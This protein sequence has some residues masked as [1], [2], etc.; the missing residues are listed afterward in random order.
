MESL[1]EECKNEQSL[2]NQTGRTWNTLREQLSELAL[3]HHIINE[4]SL[5]NG[6][7]LFG[8]EV[9]AVEAD[10]VVFQ[11]SGSSGMT[12]VLVPLVQIV[13]L[14]TDQYPIAPR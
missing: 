5:I 3:Q 10:Y 8:V 11:E 9:E 2:L 4:V 1:F 7:S 13:Y 6:Q 14:D 12:N